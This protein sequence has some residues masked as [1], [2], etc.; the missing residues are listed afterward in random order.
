MANLPTLEEFTEVCIEGVDQMAAAFE[1]P[2]ED[3]APIMQ[4]FA[5]DSQDLFVIGFDGRFLASA[6]SKDMLAERIMVPMIF[7]TGAKMLA[8]VLSAWALEI[9]GLNEQDARM[10]M[11]MAQRNGLS[12]HPNKVERVIVTAMN[13]HK[14]MI[15][16]AD[17]NRDGEN[18]PTLGE[19]D[20]MDT[21]QGGVLD[22]RFVTPLQNA[23]RDNSGKADPKFLELMRAQGLA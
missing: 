18:P 17:I 15:A 13:A 23:L 1:H 9:R 16:M 8:T 22:G 14:T 3:F 2:D 10:A 20:R 11:E 21:L 6:E 4:L 19:W 5:G 12:N 7:G